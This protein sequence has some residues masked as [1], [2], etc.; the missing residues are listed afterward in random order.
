MVQLLTSELSWKP[1][2]STLMRKERWRFTTSIEM[3]ISKNNIK[4]FALNI[5]RKNGSWKSITQFNS[6]RSKWKSLDWRMRCITSCSWKNW[7]MDNF[8]SLICKWVRLNLDSWRTWRK[9]RGRVMIL[10]HSLEILRQTN[11]K[12]KI[13]KPSSRVFLLIIMK[14]SWNQTLT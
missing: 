6:I 2:P 9:Y 10:D 11:L 7:K 13:N 4:F 5:R 12:K 8:R 1:K 3:T 14:F